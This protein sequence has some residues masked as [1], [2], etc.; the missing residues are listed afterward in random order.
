MNGRAILALLRHDLVMFFSN[1]FIAV[2][3]ALALVAYAAI[4]FLM[5]AD[6]DETFQVA[7]YAP[8]FPQT[9]F[10]ELADEGLEIAFLPTEAA[11]QQAILDGDEMVG[12]A[13]PNNFV[14]ALIRGERP[15]VTIYFAA[16]IQPEFRA[17]Y[18]L[19]FEEIAFMISGRPLNIEVTEEVLGVDRGG[20]QIPYRDR[21]LPLFVVFMLAAEIFGLASLIAAEISTGTLRALLVTPLRVEDL[22]ISKGILGVGLAFVQATLLLAITGGFQHEP[23][24]VLL[25][26][27]LGSTL[28]TGIGFLI[29]VVSRDIMST[30]AWGALPMMVLSLPAF[31]ILFP[32]SATGWVRI[33]PSYYLIE[34]LYQLL[35]E[36]A[37]WGDVGQYLLILAALSLA[38]L[39][40][41]VVALKSKFR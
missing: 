34:P 17:A 36:N 38:F 16:G 21:L 5:P 24:I 19:F 6:L 29:A 15:A 28:M 22:F 25:L 27:L 18:R 35:N 1:R 31:V 8:D 2:I 20:E 14:P 32:G 3:T 26:L 39:V 40:A 4:Y 33:I 9:I 13:L 7:L 41:G 23:L 10:Q 30:V 37:G 12:A 11:L